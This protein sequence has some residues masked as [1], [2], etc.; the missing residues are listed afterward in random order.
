ML[1]VW[2]NAADWPKSCNVMAE[3]M[4]GGVFNGNGCR[5]LCKNTDILQSQAN[6]QA[7]PF[8]AA[9]KS[10]D[11][12]VDSCFG[13]D[14]ADDFKEH[15]QAFKVKYLDLVKLGL[16]NVTPKIHTI[17]HHI[18][19]F[20]DLEGVGLGRHSE[21][22]RESVHCSFSKT[23]LKYKVGARN[24]NY[25]HK[26]L[27]TP[28]PHFGLV[29]VTLGATWGLTWCL[30]LCLTLGLAAADWGLAGLEDLTQCF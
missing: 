30:T 4:H 23:F 1:S 16:V 7:Q 11:A 6:I 2:P 18:S 29:W 24:P 28:E 27:R 26:L 9:F 22:A 12:V 20:C 25:G 15:I 8:V 21:Q 3:P 13:K 19:E 5:K 10:L 17:F 14:L